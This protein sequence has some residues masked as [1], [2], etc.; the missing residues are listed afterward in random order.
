MSLN[1]LELLYLVQLHII[2][3]WVH[4]FSLKAATEVSLRGKQTSEN[5]D[6]QATFLEP[7]WKNAT[8]KME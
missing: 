8:K 1:N 7:K 6:F 2:W 5:L 4:P 3:K